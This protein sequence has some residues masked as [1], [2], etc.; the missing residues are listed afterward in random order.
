VKKLIWFF[1]VIAIS[2]SVLFVIYFFKNA[3]KIQVIPS[4]SQKNQISPISQ[5]FVTAKVAKVIDGDTIVIDTGEHI[6]YIGINTPEMETNECYATEATMTNKNLV[7]GKTVRLEK[8]VSETDKY[9]RLLRY[10][11][12]SHP[13]LDSG[14]AFVNDELV[15]NGSARVETVPP[16]TKFKTE[17]VSSEKYAKVNKLGLWGKCP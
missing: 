12:I 13:E 17:F 10:V 11:Y 16:D 3:T 1:A 8:D 5:S 9:G 4:V 7:L 2:L 6:R 15:K 14:S